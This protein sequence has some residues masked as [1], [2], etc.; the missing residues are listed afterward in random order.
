MLAAFLEWISP[1]LVLSSQLPGSAR[2]CIDFADR[3]EREAVAV[4]IGRISKA[5]E[6]KRERMKDEEGQLGEAG[7]ME[8]RS[9]TVFHQV[10]ATGTLAVEKALAGLEAQKSLSLVLDLQSARLGDGSIRRHFL[11]QPRVLFE[12]GMLALFV[13]EKGKGGWGVAEVLRFDPMTEPGDDAEA[14]FRKGAED[15][16][17]INHR[18]SA[19]KRCLEAAEAASDPEERSAKVGELRRVLEGKVK[20][21]LPESDALLAARAGPWEK[22]LRERLAELVSGG[23]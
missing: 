4:A 1:L 9:G 14:T 12:E 11:L 19:L 6:G 7:K 18:V 20:L 3:L 15:C 13:L 16:F 2:R 5:K 21:L 22:L 17:E 8:S 23:K 10:S